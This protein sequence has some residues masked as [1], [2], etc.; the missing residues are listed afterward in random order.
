VLSALSSSPSA[1]VWSPPPRGRCVFSYNKAHLRKKLGIL[2][3]RK[4]GKHR[5]GGLGHWAIPVIPARRGAIHLCETVHS[6]LV[7]GEKR[8]RGDKALCAHTAALAAAFI[9][10]SYHASDTSPPPTGDAPRRRTVSSASNS[11]RRR[12]I[13][14]A[15]RLRL[16][17]V[18]VLASCSA[19]RSRKPGRRLTAPRWACHRA[20]RRPSSPHLGLLFLARINSKL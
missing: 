12:F 9:S 4:I 6:S 3:I 5:V 15:G 13:C 11:T 7:I 16:N 14:P 17:H 2:Y 18:C 1:T 10:P 8:C 20:P 19:S